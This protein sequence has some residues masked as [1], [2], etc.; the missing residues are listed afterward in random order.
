ML[1]PD[2]ELANRGDKLQTEVHQV[3]I[4]ARY[5]KFMILQGHGEFA[6]VNRWEGQN[7]GASSCCILE[8]LHQTENCSPCT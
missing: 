7:N 3:N 1:A 2:P 6:T 5:L 8:S 4:R